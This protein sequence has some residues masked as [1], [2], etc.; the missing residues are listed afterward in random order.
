M[1]IFKFIT[2]I[3]L[4]LAFASCAT[5]TPTDFPA[6][7]RGF[8]IG[9]T[10]LSD[11]AQIMLGMPRNE[12]DQILGVSATNDLN[13]GTYGEDES[14]TITFDEDNLAQMIMSTSTEWAIR[15][16][17]SVGNTIYDISRAEV[18]HI[19][20]DEHTFGN[21]VIMR[22]TPEDPRFGL[23]FEYDNETVITAISMAHLWPY[24]PPN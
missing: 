18:L 2:T 16:N 14:I 4:V 23:L 19:F 5:P 24:F 10:R 9:L 15:G 20:I 12:I 1:K 22:N 6:A 13:F 7:G 3:I 17:L 8:P 11:G 21:E